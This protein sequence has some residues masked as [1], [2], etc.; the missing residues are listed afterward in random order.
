VIA[1]LCILL[2]AAVIFGIAFVFA[3]AGEKQALDATR[4]A[5]SRASTDNRILRSQNSTLMAER[6]FL[7]RSIER[8]A[9][10]TR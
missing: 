4:K 2:V 10:N 5:L 1:I 3:F 9:E 7:Q 8:S 6:D